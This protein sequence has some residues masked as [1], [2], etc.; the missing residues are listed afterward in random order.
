MLQLKVIVGSTRSGR[1]AD[2]VIPWIGRRT[3]EDG[4]FDGSWFACSPAA[5]RTIVNSR[6]QR[7]DHGQRHTIQA[8]S[9]S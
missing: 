3:R 9:P 4:R 6:F 5:H 7:T 8:C 2:L 1:A